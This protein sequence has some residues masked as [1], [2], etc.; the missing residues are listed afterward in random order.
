MKRLDICKRCGKLKIVQ[1]HHLYGYNEEHKDDVAP[2]CQSCDMNAHFKA[3]KEGR[4]IL[5]HDEVN[6]KSKNSYNRRSYK[7]I[8]ITNETMMSNIQLL[9]F[10]QINLNTNHI[11]IS[12]FFHAQHGKKLKIIEV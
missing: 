6:I 4:C 5:K 12:S 9:E 1:D 8:K 11:N 3:K 2:Y 10:I 7:R